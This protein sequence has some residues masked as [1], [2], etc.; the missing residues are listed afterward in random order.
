MSFPARGLLTW[1]G[2]PSLS[3]IAN[4]KTHAARRRAK[5]SFESALKS[6]EKRAIRD[7]QVFDL[8]MLAHAP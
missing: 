4:G 2:R 8:S 5:K 1:P 6:F 3:E 7:S